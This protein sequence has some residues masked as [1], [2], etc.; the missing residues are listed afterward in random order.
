MKLLHKLQERLADRFSFVQ[1]PN[2]RPANASTRVA[3]RTGL[4]FKTAM[5]IGERFDLLMMSLALLAAGIA[6]LVVVGFL[7]YVVV[8]TSL[9]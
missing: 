5:P 1:Y 9:K 8:S 7:I 4:T 3:S 6:G 2:I